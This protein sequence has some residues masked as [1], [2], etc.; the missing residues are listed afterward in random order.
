MK[1]RFSK[2]L[3]F[4]AVIGVTVAIFGYGTGLKVQAQT[5]TVAE[6]DSDLSDNSLVTNAVPLNASPVAIPENLSPGLAE[7]IKLAQS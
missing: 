3:K 2:G 1:T 5:E 4:L 7:I 6:T